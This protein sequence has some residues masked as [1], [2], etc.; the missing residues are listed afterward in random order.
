M[1]LLDFSCFTTCCF[2]KILTFL[3][4]SR[5]HLQK[6]K[7]SQ[8]DAGSAPATPAKGGKAR[9]TKG[10]ATKGKGSGT[11][12]YPVD[13]DDPVEDDSDYAETATPTKRK[14]KTE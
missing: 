9:A 1:D 5:Q 2:S 7:R 6:L 11:K 14:A 4:S 13:L 10:S 8:G 12:G 3:L